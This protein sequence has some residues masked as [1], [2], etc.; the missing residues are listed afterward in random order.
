MKLLI[1]K[2]ADVNAGGEMCGWRNWNFANSELILLLGDR[3]FASKFR[4]EYVEILKSPIEKG[5]DV[6]SGSEMS[7]NW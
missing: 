7:A 1:E 6:N 3:A 5:I 4:P 2:G